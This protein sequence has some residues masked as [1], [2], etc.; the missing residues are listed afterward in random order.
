M[1][2]GT[3]RLMR[4]GTALRAGRGREPAPTASLR[5][6]TDGTECRPY[7]RCAHSRFL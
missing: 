3:M 2:E 6:P 4:A 7:L 1:T 5:S